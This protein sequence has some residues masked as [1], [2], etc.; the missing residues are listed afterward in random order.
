MERCLPYLLRR[1]LVFFVILLAFP[2]VSFLLLKTGWLYSDTLVTTGIFFILVMG[3]D[4][5]YGASGQLSLGHQGFFAIG[6]Y[7]AAILAKQFD[8]SPWI[9]AL[10]AL[11]VNLLLALTLGR[12]LLRLTGLYF[13]LG[14]LAFGIMVHAVITVWHPVTGGDAG[15]G[16]VP[17]PRLGGIPL[18]SELAYGALVWVIAFA[19]F[20]A[21]L[22]LARSRVGRALR[23]IRGDEVSAAASGIHV[24][25]LKANVLGLSA[26]YAS[27]AGSLFAAYFGAVHPESF[28]LSALLELLLMLFLGGEGTIWGGLLGAGLLRLL[29]DVSGPLHAYKILFSGVV[30]TL[31]LFLFPKGLAGG[32]EGLISRV[33]AFRRGRPLPGKG[34]PALPSLTPASSN[35]NGLLLTVSDVVRTF[36]G[37]FAVDGVSFGVAPGQIKSL[38]GPNGAG[39]TTL[40]NLISGVYPSDRGRIE[41]LSQNLGVLRSDQIARLG[42]RRTFQNVRLFEELSVLENVMV[43]C[44][45]GQQ[46]G[47]LEMAGAGLP[48]PAA[49]HEELDLRREAGHWLE[50]VGLEHRAEARPTALPY[51]HRKLVE[52]ARAAAARPAFLLLDEAAAGLN[53]AE[54][55]AFKALIRQLRGSGATILLVE[56]DMDFVMELSD[57][58]LVVNFGRKIAEGSPSAVRKDPEVLA[59]YLGV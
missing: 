57:E 13:M 44:A 41:F 8:A 46:G 7:T 6:A 11:C 53:D 52:L 3:L 15:L 14:T 42:V 33:Q 47:I 5:L 28:S 24:M 55:Q 43:G 18:T 20:W 32:I 29:P 56:H 21:A 48:L 40:L 26:A 16:G 2:P 1:N 22:N 17:R 23:A 58:V 27:V 45:R 10:A 38:I 54:K 49:I 51:G 31:I 37:V 34:V 50:R 36:G 30:F 59:A 9:G 39:K 19:L 25:R 4:L 12:I 35:S